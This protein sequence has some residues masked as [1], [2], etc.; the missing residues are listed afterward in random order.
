MSIYALP[1]I[2]RQ[3]ILLTAVAA[4]P[5][6]LLTA[7][8]AQIAVPLPWTPVPVT[9]QVFVVL[10]SAGLLGPGTAFV[11]QVEYLSMGLAGAPVFAGMRAGPAALLGPTG[12]YIIAFAPASLI[13]GAVARRRTWPAVLTGCLL[14]V[15]TIH[16][17]GLLWIQLTTGV[18]W[19]KA[20]ALASAPFI[21]VDVVKVAAATVVIRYAD[22][23]SLS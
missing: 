8:S 9:L 5:A 18:S 16:I 19:A 20:F 15:A 21:I 13:C 12:G 17:V 4:L 11:A 23:T 2:R 7:L 1:T 6:A 22:Q 14:A 3:G 10:V